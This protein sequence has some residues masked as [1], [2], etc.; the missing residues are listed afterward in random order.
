M[1]DKYLLGI[2]IGS[3]SVKLALLEIATGTPAATAFSPSAEMPMIS[4]RQGFAEQDPELW[5]KE[6]GNAMRLLRSR[7]AFNGEDIAAIGISYQMHGL[8][9]IDKEGRPLRNVIIWCDSRAVDIGARAFKALGEEYCLRNFLNTPGNFTASKLRWVRENEPDIYQKIYK[10]ML[11]GDYIAMKLTGD[12]ATTIPGL[13]EGILWNFSRNALATELLDHYEIDPSLICPVVETFGGQG[14]LTTEAAGALGLKAGIP[15]AYRAG[16]QPNNAYSLNVLQPGEFAATAGTSGVVYGITDKAAYDAASRVNSFVHVNHSVNEPRYGVLLCINGTG[17]L[18]SWL[19]NNFFN[20]LSY[21]EINAKA[22]AAPA[23]CEGLLFYPFGNGAERVLENKD[24]GAML[25]GLQFNRHGQG[26]IARAAKEGIVFSMCYGINVMESM[27]MKAKTVRAG[28]ANMFL[29]PVFAEAFANTTGAV[30]ELFDT[31]GAV[32][33]ARAAGVGAGIYKEHKDG[34]AGM[35]KIKT[36][37]PAAESSG[38]YGEIYEKW[39]KGID[40]C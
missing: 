10:A 26:H 14:L 23:G 29:S 20:H 32:G 4:L 25:K 31:D 7:H 28:Y 40:Y 27:G 9:C 11:P 30:L 39:K 38:I 35:K 33:A 3:S 36:I 24:P 37:E 12:P 18:Y 2:D 34:F 5:W 17:I 21:E 8:V 13:S 1:S 6:L 15:V 22:A 19:K 16:D